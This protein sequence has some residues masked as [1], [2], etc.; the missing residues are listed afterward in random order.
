[1]LV[2]EFA[3]APDLHLGYTVPSV[4]SCL[5]GVVRLNYSPIRGALEQTT[6]T[7]KSD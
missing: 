7:R 1:M 5:R 4:R 6:D 2:H 3:P